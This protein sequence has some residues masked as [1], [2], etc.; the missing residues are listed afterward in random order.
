MTKEKEKPAQL[1]ARVFKKHRIIVRK[2][3]KANKVSEAE[4]VRR[5][6]EAYGQ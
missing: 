2:L 4:I 3:A 1:G 5:A 6:I